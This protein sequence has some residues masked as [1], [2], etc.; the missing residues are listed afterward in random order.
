MFELSVV[1]FKG[2]CNETIIQE[3]TQRLFSSLHPALASI[4][5][6]VLTAVGVKS[7]HKL[8]IYGCRSFVRAFDD[9]LSSVKFLCR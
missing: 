8:S 4:V 3:V 1:L 9:L 7:Q 6:Q 5:G 2:F